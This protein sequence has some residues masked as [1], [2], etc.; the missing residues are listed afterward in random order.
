SAIVFGDQAKSSNK[1]IADLLEAGADDFV[2]K[3]IDERILVAKLK[4]HIRRLMPAISERS[5]RATSS[6]GAIEVDRLR[7]SVKV[8]AAK[9]RRTEIL[10]L[11]Q[12]ELDILTFLIDHEKQVVSRETM[13]ERIWG[14]GAVDVYSECV[15]KHIE[16]L[17][18]KLGL[19][20][21]KIRTVYGAGY[22]FNGESPVK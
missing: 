4:A 16:S 13:L 3:N 1:L 8:Q 20:G 10:N 12:R 22:M 7:H 9:G 21:K 11:T 5:A 15:D 6:C 17:R 2:Y 18:R 19:C 14:E